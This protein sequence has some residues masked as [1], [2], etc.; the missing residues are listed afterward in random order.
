MLDD[1]LKALVYLANIDR[2]HPVPDA[3]LPREPFGVLLLIHLPCCR[4]IVRV[5]ALFAHD[6]LE[7]TRRMRSPCCARAASGHAAEQCDEIAAFQP[8]QTACG[9]QTSFRGLAQPAPDTAPM[10]PPIH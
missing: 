9:V 6:F 8:D 5:L 7:P 1:G 2:H 4:P 10:H 3:D